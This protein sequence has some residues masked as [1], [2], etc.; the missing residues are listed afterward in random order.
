[1]AGFRFPVMLF[2]DSTGKFAQG[3]LSPSVKENRNVVLSQPRKTS[4]NHQSFPEIDPVWC[5]LDTFLVIPAQ[6]TAESQ[7]TE[8]S[9]VRLVEVLKYEFLRIR[10]RTLRLYP[11]ESK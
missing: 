2:L 5:F 6:H 7:V 11:C 10:S 4:E 1:M 9:F 8:K 3:V